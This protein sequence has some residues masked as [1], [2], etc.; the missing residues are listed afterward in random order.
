MDKHYSVR[1]PRELFCYSVEVIGYI[2]FHM[3][4]GYTYREI[5]VLYVY[6]T[7]VLHIRDLRH[8]FYTKTSRQCCYESLFLY[9]V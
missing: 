1:N 6:M 2:F 7:L 3:G 8:Y 5:V 9:S 4:Y